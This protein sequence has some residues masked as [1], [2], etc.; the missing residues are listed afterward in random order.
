MGILVTAPRVQ[1]IGSQGHGLVRD[2]AAARCR[3]TYSVQSLEELCFQPKGMKAQGCHDIY[4]GHST[5]ALPPSWLGTVQV[6]FS[7]SN[8]NL[9]KY[10]MGAQSREETHG[11]GRI[12]SSVRL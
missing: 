2:T 10:K 1:M 11:F 9:A 6:T 4:P 3:L 7:T 8:M 5:F 12:S